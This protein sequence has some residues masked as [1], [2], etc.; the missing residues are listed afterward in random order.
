VAPNNK[1]STHSPDCIGPSPMLPSIICT[2]HINVHPSHQWCRWP[3][4]CRHTKPPTQKAKSHHP[5]LIINLHNA[6]LS[7]FPPIIALFQIFNFKTNWFKFKVQN[8]KSSNGKN[9]GKNLSYVIVH[10]SYLSPHSLN[11]VHAQIR[12]DKWRVTLHQTPQELN[13]PTKMWVV[14][15]LKK[16]ANA[17]RCF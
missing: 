7:H 4:L 14:Y 13:G 2:H 8:C 11:Y 6:S 16:Y 5:P 12:F 9:I 15:S 10:V 3:C 1:R 17:N